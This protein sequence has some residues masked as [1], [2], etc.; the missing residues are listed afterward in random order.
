MDLLAPHL[1]F[2]F[3]KINHQPDG[4]FPRGV[5]NPLLPENRTETTRAVLESG[6]DLGIAWDGDFDRCFFWD[7]QGNFIE[8]YY[9]VGLLAEEMLKK[10]PGSK[11]LYDPRLI[12]NTEEL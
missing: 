3:I 1:P 9:I 6:A 5:P 4:T 11:I 7:E 10:Q 12:W 8:G 2:N